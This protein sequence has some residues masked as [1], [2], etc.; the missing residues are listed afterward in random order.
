MFSDIFC[1]HKSKD[2]FWFRI[3]KHGLCFKTN[4]SFSQRIGKSKYIKLGKWIITYL[5]PYKSE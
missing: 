4:M 3:F 2:I 1:Y 5:K